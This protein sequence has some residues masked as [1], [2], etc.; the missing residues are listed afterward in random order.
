MLDQGTEE[1]V[2]VMSTTFTAEPDASFSVEGLQDGTPFIY[3]RWGNPTVDQLERK[4][5]SLE[6]AESCIAFASGMAAVTA[7]FLHTL[8][9]GDHVVVSDVAYA[10]T[11]EMTNE[12]LPRFGIRVTKANLSDLDELSAAL[13][14]R[15][16]LVYAESPCNPLLRLTDI[17]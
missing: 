4:L 10:A 12:L 8:N 17:A 2:Q 5:V 3:T 1:S 7:L 11:A 16:R 14:P 9:A 15:T 13:T 6:D